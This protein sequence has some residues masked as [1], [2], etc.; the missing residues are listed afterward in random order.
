MLSL[1]EIV[2]KKVLDNYILPQECIESLIFQKIYRL[3]VETYVIN[4]FDFPNDITRLIHTNFDK[5]VF[6][7]LKC[8]KTDNIKLNEYDE[9]N[10]KWSY[11]F[12]DYGPKLF[13]EELSI[14]NLISFNDKI[15]IYYFQNGKLLKKICNKF[16][17][18]EEIDT[19]FVFENE[20]LNNFD[21]NISNGFSL[22]VFTKWINGIT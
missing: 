21:F 9:K 15:I 7:M 5:C 22:K 17:V 20:F 12:T 3:S 14:G 19:S 11:N 4:R 6:E 2:G 10:N 16:P 13:I 18:T 1:K 8:F